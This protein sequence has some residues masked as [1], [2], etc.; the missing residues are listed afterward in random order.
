M[1]HASCTP[2][3]SSGVEA[4]GYKA[5]TCPATANKAGAAQRN[6]EIFLVYASVNAARRFLRGLPF[7]GL[8]QDRRGPQAQL[9]A[10]A[11]FVKRSRVEEGLPLPSLRAVSPFTHRVRTRKEASKLVNRECISTGFV[12][13]DKHILYIGIVEW[14]KSTRFWAER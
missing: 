2:R 14:E 13:A 5:E 8:R 3:V 9:Q 10:H 12:A 1:V 4:S 6:V 11:A 7:V